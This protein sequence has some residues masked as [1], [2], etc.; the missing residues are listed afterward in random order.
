MHIMYLYTSIYVYL[1]CIMQQ[2]RS[3]YITCSPVENMRMYSQRL[4]QADLFK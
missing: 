1:E 3:N 4:C 2:M